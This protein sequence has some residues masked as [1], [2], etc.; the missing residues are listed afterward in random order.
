MSR[1]ST[2][3]PT[4]MPQGAWIISRALA[5]RATVSPAMA[6][7]DAEEAA[8]PSTAMVTRASLRLRCRALWIARP[9][10]TEPP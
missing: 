4:A 10:L 1:M 2:A 5:A 6:I 7:M 8:T 9:S 3:L